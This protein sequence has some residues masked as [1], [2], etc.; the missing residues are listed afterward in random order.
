MNAHITVSLSLIGQV[1]CESDVP[2]SYSATL[3]GTSYLPRPLIIM[4]SPILS[5]ATAAPTVTQQPIR[6]PHAGETHERSG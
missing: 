4:G 1:A 5:P 2:G 6:M 3:N